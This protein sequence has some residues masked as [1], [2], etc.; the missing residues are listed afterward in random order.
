MSGWH[1]AVGLLLCLLLG[2]CAGTPERGAASP[3]PEGIT[4]EEA[5]ELPPLAP[6]HVSVQRSDGRVLV[7]WHGTGS[8]VA[9][10][11]V[12][13]RVG[14]DQAWQLLGCVPA[15][16]ADSGEYQ[17]IDPSPVAGSVY[18]VAAVSPHGVRSD[19]AVP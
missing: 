5:R 4:A 8:P 2:G 16:P 3:A 6:A 13:R 9:R 14:A 19:I 17:W 7:A 10:Y 12:Y 15:N 1:V 11:E 18:G